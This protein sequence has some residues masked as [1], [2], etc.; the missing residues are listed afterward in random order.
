MGQCP[1]GQSTA[2]F[3]RDGSISYGRDANQIPPTYTV[4]Y[5]NI[6]GGFT[7]TGNIDADPQFVD[8]ANGNYR[9]LSNSP[10]VN[11]GD[12]NST[13]T[14]V[15]ATDL[16][17]NPRVRQNRIDMGVYEFQGETKIYTIIAGNW[18]TPA[19]W[20]VNRLPLAGER[21]QLRY[22]ITLPAAYRAQA[23]WLSY[24]AGGQLIYSAG[25]SLRLTP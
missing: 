25:A 10:S 17:G 11:T 6:Q 22:R 4:T 5:S 13:T 19:V 20:S 9:L 14:T 8:A 12:P 23:G 1:A 3:I 24:D 16:A 21:I 18:S 2:K 15:S 7:G